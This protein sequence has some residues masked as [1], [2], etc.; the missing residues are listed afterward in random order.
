MKRALE[1]HRTLFSSSPRGGKKIERRQGLRWLVDAALPLALTFVVAAIAFAVDGLDANGRWVLFACA[2]A[3]VLWSTTRIDAAYVALGAALLLVL[4]G[5]V[6]A[7][8]LH[9]S[10]ASDVVWLMIGAFI[11]G[12]ALRDT[13]VTTRLTRVL[14]ARART[15]A[16]A[17]FW[18]TTAIVPLAFI[19]PS[20]SARAAM[21][22]PIYE[23]LAS[24][25]RDRRG[26]RAF[27][28]LV[29]SVI[30]ISTV[31][32]LVAAGSHL[33]SE[34][35]LEQAT[36]ETIGYLR[37]LAWGAPFA[38]VTSAL[39]AAAV[40]FAFLPRSLR[41]RPL[42][43]PA[44]EEGKID[45]A[46]WTTI[47][48]VA[49]M[50]VLWL[51]T[52]IHHLDV[53]IVTLLGAIL[54]TV[55]KGGVITWSQGLKAV[56]WSLVLFVGA[57]LVLG[58]ALI[59]SGVGTFLLDKLLPRGPG[60]GAQAPILFGA[61][62][63]LSTVTAHLYMPSHAARAAAFVPPL[64]HLASS[65]DLN[66]L[67]VVFFANLGLDYCLTFPIS[68]KALLVYQ[69]L[70]RETFDAADLMRLSALLMPLYALA[71][72]AFYFAYWRWTGAAF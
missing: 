56:S 12:G 47:A 2:E 61:L 32:S 65:A 48:V 30:L 16:G 36:G 69:Q 23:D 42:S 62:L 59:D 46:G 11:V 1:R 60:V 26:R 18:L 64:L 45:G 31:G 63:A 67:A 17:A 3:T 34:Q 55:P 13:G 53:S 9:D 39:T 35:L 33:I 6:P 38:V 28:L 43:L 40:V 20:T 22:L 70:D 50:V 7:E 10:L 37:W 24:A 5:A 8:T 4:V 58:E 72:L 49:V 68:S 14:L 15:V 27:A 54:L 57:A 25:L 44:P 19:I 29:P 51:T 66:P 41:W 21:L 71:M 52:S